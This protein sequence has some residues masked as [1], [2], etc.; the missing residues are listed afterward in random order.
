MNKALKTIIGTCLISSMIL[1]TGCATESMEF[2]TA[3]TALRSEKDFARAEIWFK[4]ALIADS[5]NAMVPYIFATEILRP[6]KRYKEMAEMFE[7]ALRRNPDA[8]LDT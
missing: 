1:L 8:K 6:Q 5:L 7:E 2:T 3:K 4:K